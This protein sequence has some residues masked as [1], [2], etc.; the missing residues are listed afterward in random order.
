MSV[1]AF[2]WALTVPVGG[3]AKVILLGL[4]NH[5]HPD[6]SEAYPALDRLALYAHCDRSTARRNVRKLADDGWIVEDGY[7][8]KGQVKYRLAMTAEPMRGGGE[9]PPVRQTPP[10]ASVPEGGGASASGGVAPMPPEPSKEPSIEP[11]TERE[12][13]RAGEKE[14][15]EDFPD[16]LRPHARAVYRILTSVAEHHNAKAISAPALAHVLMAR[17]HHPLVEAAHDYAA[18]AMTATRRKDVVAGYR[19]W[20]AK[21]SEL[22]GTERL[23]GTSPPSTTVVPAGV[24]SLHGRRLSR[25]ERKEEQILGL[26][27]A[28]GEIS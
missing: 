24:T 17:P 22:A 19:N 28:A 13:A 23:P 14:I 6:G 1:E 4:A 11:S 25:G 15:P 3:N 18:W 26:L 10:V 8:P 21:C 2:G 9:M 27:R 20:L 5:A 12:S 16:E 7:G